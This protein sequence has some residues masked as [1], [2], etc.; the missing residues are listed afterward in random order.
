MQQRRS[1]SVA[2]VAVVVV[3]L[4]LGAW[5]WF[6]E[7]TDEFA[8]APAVGEPSESVSK[9]APSALA[10]IEANPLPSRAS[11]AVEVQPAPT[12]EAAAT[13]DVLA[14]LERFAKENRGLLSSTLPLTR[15]DHDVEYGDSTILAELALVFSGLRVP[16]EHF[17]HLFDEDRRD[18]RLHN[19]AL[20]AVVLATLALE[21]VGDVWA[22]T[23]L[24]AA[25]ERLMNESV[26]PATVSP[27]WA[28]EFPIVD[29]AY[30]ARVIA[31]RRDGEF[32]LELIE[33]C[34]A[35]A[36]PQ[37]AYFPMAYRQVLKGY[38]PWTARDMGARLV[39]LRDVL[40]HDWGGAGADALLVAAGADEYSGI[41]HLRETLAKRHLADDLAHILRRAPLR[42]SDVMTAILDGREDE[43]AF[44]GALVGLLHL[45][46]PVAALL[47]G[48]EPRRP[49]HVMALTKALGRVASP[50]ALTS[51]VGLWRHPM[52]DAHLR[53]LVRAALRRS[54]APY[55]WDPV[56]ANERGFARDLMLSLGDETVVPATWLA[57]W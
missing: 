35:K 6:G 43:R 40:R 4:F 7:S 29:L 38:E 48:P 37:S 54:L 39:A 25:F 41:A 45:G 56:L 9:P 16:D 11:A 5:W 57:R 33:R 18:R 46:H 44:V 28:R 55:V 32:A 23:Q 53:Q 47:D 51:L 50:A 13:V 21:P 30:V 27:G 42:H 31:W 19:S 49:L 14:V 3:A 34:A 15:D 24:R 8:R 17:T 52:L 10:A 2:V 12:P 20:R 26:D 22:S 1:K 36:T